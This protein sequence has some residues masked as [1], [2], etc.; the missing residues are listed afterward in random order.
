MVAVIN[1]FGGFYSRE[2]YF[3]ELL[4]C[5][6]D[7]HLPCVNHSDHYTNIHNQKVYVGFIHIK[8]LQN[9]LIEALLEERNQNGAFTSLTDFIERTNPG[10]EQLNILIRIGAFRF[11]NKSK[12]TLLWEANFL[13]K[14]ASVEPPEVQSMFDE[15]LQFGFELPQLSDDPI[16]DLYDQMEIMNFCTTNPFA[17]VDEDPKKYVAAKDMAH[18]SDK[19][20]TMLAYFIARKHVITKNDDAMFFGTFV[21]ANLDWIDTVHFPDAAKRH[22]LHTSGFYKIKG[23]VAEDFGVYSL[24]VSW[25]EKCGYK[26]RSY[27]N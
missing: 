18:H 23:K 24:E 25:M 16:D 22:P 2:L 9:K 14:K 5:G 6:G 21:D 27:A 1:N 8:G 17:L 10:L 3:L 12:K 4:K 26:N 7:I 11:T 19:T 13:Q 15:P 20:I